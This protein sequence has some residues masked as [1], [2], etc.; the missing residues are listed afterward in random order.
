MALYSYGSKGDEVKK[1][2]NALNRAGYNLS[3]DGIYGE[4]TQAAVKQYQQ[5]NGLNVDGIV[6]S[7][8]WG[9]LFGGGSSGTSGTGAS[10]SAG[11][12]TQKTPMGTEYDPSKTGGAQADLNAIEGAM[13]Q[14]KPSQEYTDALAALRQHQTT[15][16]AEYVSPFNDRLNALYEQVMGRGDFNYDFNADALYH[17]Y[18]DRYAEEGRRAMQDTM[19][20][21]AALTGGYG[22]SYAQTAGQQAY[23]QYMQAANDVIPTLEQRA[24]ERWLAEN[25]GAMEQLQLLRDMDAT[26]YARHMDGRNDYWTTLE[27]LT[28][29][30]GDQYGRDYQQYQDA[31]NMFLANRDYYADKAAQEAAAKGSGGSSGG[32]ASK[33]NGSNTKQSYS[34]G[35]N[36]REIAGEVAAGVA[37]TAGNI[38]AL[39]STTKKLTLD[40]AERYLQEIRETEGMTAAEEERQHLL[41]NDLITWK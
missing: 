14:Y 20:N 5:A 25:N 32:S 6:G 30:A 16:P 12:T 34:A 13:P 9:K 1:L 11:A 2:Q 4:K 26:E 3:E 8:T 40:E 28:G 19:A 33:G 17:Q 41:K 35:K 36:I 38:A 29:A 22:N 37:G 21:A 24:F 7:Q 15:K 39:I 18:R 23:N 27:Y 10:S 31:L